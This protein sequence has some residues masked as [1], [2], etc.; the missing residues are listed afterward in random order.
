MMGPGRRPLL[1]SQHLPSPPRRFPW[2]DVAAP[3]I[4]VAALLVTAVLSTSRDPFWMDEWLSW[5]LLSDPSLSHML[6]ANTD[7]I[8]VAP[9]AYFVLGHA[10][11][12]IFGAD[13]LALRL[14]TSVSFAGGLLALWWAL[15]A[16]HGRWSA[17]TATLIAI[18]SCVALQR[19]NVEARFYGLFFAQIA[20]GTALAVALARQRRPTFGLLAATAL[21]HAALCLTNYFGF[22]YSGALLVA[23]LLAHWRRPRA[24]VRVA[25]S[26]ALGWCAFLPWIPAFQNHT[27]LGGQGY[28]TPQPYLP[29]LFEVYG[30]QQ[31]MG[32]TALVFAAAAAVVEAVRKRAVAPLRSSSP[33]PDHRVESAT[34]DARLTL[35]LVAFTFGLVPLAT[36]VFSQ[37]GTSLFLQ[38][39]LFPT[40]ISFAVLWAELARRILHRAGQLQPGTPGARLAHI[41]PRALF[42]LVVA[43]HVLLPLEIYRNRPLVT[44]QVDD[45][46]ARSGLPIVVEHAH[47]YL[48]FAGYSRFPERYLF[49]L[50]EEFVRSGESTR[51]GLTNHQLI[52]ALARH[53]DAVHAVAVAAFL[54]QH[55]RFIVVDS[56]KHNWFDLCILGDRRFT[57][58]ALKEAPG[59]YLVTRVGRS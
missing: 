8:N 37:S 55:E 23:Q 33:R 56:P 30:L 41:A 16:A 28:W 9:P 59:R 29:Q 34:A 57:V 18:C 46:D 52:E 42:V 58:E 4:G 49:V 48:H 22:V 39:Y 31:Y 5:Y 1:V 47:D 36:W 21:V 3:L 19:H 15:R 7:V 20:A 10:W 12:R 50:D 53:Y 11:A 44:A 38:R 25:G 40:L 13:V 24:A 35:Q 54:A 2:I 45:L 32:F 6:A 27:A 51:N 43:V 26:I 14:F 17:A